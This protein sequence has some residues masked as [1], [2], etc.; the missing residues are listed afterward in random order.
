MKNGNYELIWLDRTL[1]T[2]CWILKLTQIQS[3]Y[4]PECECDMVGFRGLF[5]RLFYVDDL[6]AVSIL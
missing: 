4:E 6:F 1:D 2:K 5:I 3:Q